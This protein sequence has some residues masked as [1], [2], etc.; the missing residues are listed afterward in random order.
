MPQK[1]IRR[2]IKADIL[3]GSIVF[4]LLICAVLSYEA[5]RI[6]RTTLTTRYET[7]SEDLLKTLD[8]M[9]DKE[10]LKECMRTEEPNSG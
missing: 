1:K 9:I 8:H 6:M 3:I 10:D 7:V 2:P 4:V 5:Y